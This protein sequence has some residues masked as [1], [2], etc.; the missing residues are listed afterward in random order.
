MTKMGGCLVKEE[1]PPKWL[2]E[3]TMS[4]TPGFNEPPNVAS[5][6][7]DFPNTLRFLEDHFHLIFEM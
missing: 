2:E 4:T 6:K 1:I 5:P 7:P 3:I